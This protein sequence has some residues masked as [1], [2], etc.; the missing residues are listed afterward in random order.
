M[1][2]G[3]FA[4]K[5]PSCGAPLSYSAE[6]LDFHCE[7]C[8]SHFSKAQLDGPLHEDG[9]QVTEAEREF[10]EQE[11][12]DE[13]RVTF[14]N[15]NMLYNCPGCGASIFTESELSA[16]AEC[17]YCHSPVVLGGRLSGE[18]RPD[19]M[20]PF[21]KTRE[22]AEKQFYEW[23]KP[24][25]F[26]IARGFGSR[27]SIS[28]MQGIYIPFW[29]ADCKVN[30]SITADCTKTISSSRQGDYIVTTEAKSKAVRQGSVEFKGVPADASSKADDALMDSIEPFDYSQLIDFDLSYLSGHSALRYDV[31]KEMSEQR[32]ATRVVTAAEE[33]F[34]KDITGY[35][36]VNVTSKDIRLTGINYLQAMMPMWFMT[37]KYNDK[38]YYFAMN[39]Q[40]GKFGGEI[41]INK[42]KVALFSF[43]IPLAVAAVIAALVSFVGAIV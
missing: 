31:T 28:R 20:I 2:N 6:S 4:Y 26:W 14:G 11:G 35:T 12:T 39:G 17:V 24:K 33:E 23:I 22:D 27:E 1:E 21:K 10:Y 25:K 36:R 9:Q 3:S 40:T 42:G 41:P 7:Y 15:D 30:G 32:I 38:Q 19:R 18:Y 29:L 5:C 13:R 34:V 37:F 16:S 43:L 8:G